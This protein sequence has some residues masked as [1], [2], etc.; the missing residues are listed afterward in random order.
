MALEA[1]GIEFI[2]QKEPDWIRTQPNNPGYDLYKVDA[3]GN[4]TA[5]C[6]VKAMGT[7]LDGRPATMTR[8]QFEEAQLRRSRYWL[9]VV[10]NANTNEPHIIAIQ[11]PAGKARTFTFDKGWR[12]IAASDG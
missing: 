5:Y 6:E 4:V 9:Y 2:L 12:S 7:N 10:E 11:D 8:R 3:N 1:A